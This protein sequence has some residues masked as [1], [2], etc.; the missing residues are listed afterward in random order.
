MFSAMLIVFT[1]LQDSFEL[2][3]Q[4]LLDYYYIPLHLQSWIYRLFNLWSA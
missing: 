1:S 2:K 3:V 4:R